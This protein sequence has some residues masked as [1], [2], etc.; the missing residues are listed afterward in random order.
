ME[1]NILNARPIFNACAFAFANE[2]KS[3]PIP[4]ESKFSRD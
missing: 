2:D 1:P 4:H 3:L